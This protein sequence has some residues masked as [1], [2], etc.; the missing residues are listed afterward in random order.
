VAIA[1]LVHGRTHSAF[2]TA[3][4]YALIYLPPIADGPLLTDLTAIPGTPFRCLCLLLFCAVLP[5]APRRCPTC[6]LAIS[7]CSA[8]GRL[9]LRTLTGAEA[10]A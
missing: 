5:G 3:L 1:I 7:S 4:A 2:R 9:P 10:G 6:C 8:A